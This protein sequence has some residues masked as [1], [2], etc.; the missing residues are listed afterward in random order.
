MTHATG[1]EDHVVERADAGPR[2]P[3]A[4]ILLTLNE[5]LNLPKA[6]ASIDGRAPVIVV[7]SG[8]TDRTV[9]LAAAAGAT[10]LE[11]PF[12][13]YA[14]QRN[15]ALERAA[16]RYRWVFFLDADE[17]LTPA[18][19]RAL[20]D[21][22][23][24]DAVDGA[25]VR[26]DVR[27]LGHRLVHGEYRDA[28]VL[29]LMRPD[30]ARFHRAV[31]ERVDDRALRVTTLDARLIHRDAKPL[32][33]LFHKHIRYAQ[34]E[35]LAYLERDVGGTLDGFHLRTKAGRMIGLRWLY[36]QTPLFARPLIRSVRGLVLRGAWRD[37]VP[38]LVHSSM[39][40]F[41]FPLLVDLFI[42]EEKLRRAGALAR[43]FAPRGRD[44]DEG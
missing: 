32:A 6:L 37:G 26:L 29:R 16:P 12:E 25:Y 35:A 34:R 24:E 40:A 11:H 42:Y 1:P 28:R 14:A 33:E 5:E 9:A 21:T 31:N 17:E 3:L 19:W 20:E 38:G 27:W 10:V 23:R 43:E 44:P 4:I 41:W 18:L 22:I 8:S 39:K 7:D 36:N 13:N 15:Y 30:K 2:A